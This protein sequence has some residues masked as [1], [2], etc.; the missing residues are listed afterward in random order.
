MSDTIHDKRQFYI[1]GSWVDPVAANDFDVID[2]S[3]EEV[4]AVISLGSEADTNAAVA[5]AKAAFPGW[6]ATPVEERIELL[7]KL[8]EIYK[9]RSA[10]MAHA[11]STEMGAPQDLSLIHI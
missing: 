11:I 2:P 9:S 3:K 4:T 10:E 5:A 8:L 6:A 1:N 7:E